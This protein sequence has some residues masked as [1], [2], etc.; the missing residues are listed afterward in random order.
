MQGYFGVTD[1]Q[2]ARSGLTRFDSKSGIKDAG[3]YV[4]VSYALSQQWQ[5]DGQ[6]G[7]W[8]LLNDAA[9]SPLVNNSGSENQVRGLLGFS[10]RF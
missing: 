9:D 2:A 10:Y 8:Q 6:L 1:A 5:I 3:I 7:Y 4:K